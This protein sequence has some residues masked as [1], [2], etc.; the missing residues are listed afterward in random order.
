MAQGIATGLTKE[1]MLAM[2]AATVV[3]GT[4]QNGRLI[5]ARRNGTTFDA[6]PV[7]GGKGDPGTAGS[8]AGTASFIS[9]IPSAT[10]DA[11]LLRDKRIWTPKTRRVGTL[12]EAVIVGSSNAVAGT[13]AEEFCAAWG[14]TMRN[15]AIGGSGFTSSQNFLSQ[16][17][18]AA[19][20]TS[21]TESDVGVVVICDAS[22]NI[23]GWNNAGN[24]VDVSADA[25]ATFAYARTTFPNARIIC[26]PVI[27]PSD[28]VGDVAG[29]PGGYQIAWSKGLMETMQ[30]LQ[31]MCLKNNVEFVDQSWTWLSGISGV[32]A[33][34]GSVHPNTA[35]YS[36]IAKW[37]SKHV[38]G[39][40]TRRDMPWMP[41]PYTNAQAIG[42]SPVLQIRREGWNVYL[43]GSIQTTAPGS[44]GL[45]DIA[46]LP[47]GLRPPYG[48]ELTMRENG[49]SIPTAVQIYPVGVM[50]VWSALP[51][52]EQYYISGTY[53]LS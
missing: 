6:G 48:W 33:S 38:R 27:W 2:E 19:T 23:R 41:V 20:S 5:L 28:P 29:V 39:E 53:T 21:F 47:E 30:T 40:S 1:R 46:T 8:D 14:L 45:T 24:V 10:N 17:Q 7:Q 25:D 9:T 43:N 4:V 34:D 49:T 44:G 22:N 51:A 37:L 18:T 36:Q 12:K 15:Y 16:L 31:T 50:R 32:M 52:G 42:G 26:L 11:L 35:G 13:W 3:G